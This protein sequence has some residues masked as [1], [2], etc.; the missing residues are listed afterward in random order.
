M[1]RPV[2]RIRGAA[3]PDLGARGLGLPCRAADLGEAG[4]APG[5][6]ARQGEEGH[7]EAVEGEEE[8][9][10]GCRAAQGRGEGQEGPGL[11]DPCAQGEE[12]GGPA[13]ARWHR[14]AG[15]PRRGRGPRS[16]RRSG[17][18]CGSPVRPCHWRSAACRM[19]PGGCGGRSPGG[20]RHPKRSR[21]VAGGAAH[22]GRPRRQRSRGRDLARAPRARRRARRRRRRAQGRTPRDLV[23]VDVDRL[24]RGHVAPALPASRHPHQ[25][26]QHSWSGVGHL[27][28][29]RG[30]AGTG[31]RRA[32]RD[33]PRRARQHPR[34]GPRRGSG[35]GPRSGRG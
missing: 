4:A 25:E 26:D 12:R 9:R 27:G 3:A 23:G 19:G 7:P 15:S 6:H 21:K 22:R 8:R 28:R 30:R 18:R 32:R 16:A 2:H 13:G 24:G 35:R 17:G 1:P 29:P 14:R 33:R 20:D 10:P 34:P 31:P 11:E 5:R